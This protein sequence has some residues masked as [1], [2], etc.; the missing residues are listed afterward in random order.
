MNSVLNLKS[1]KKLEKLVA[2]ELKEA[3]PSNLSDLIDELFNEKETRV[4]GNT[5]GTDNKE[6]S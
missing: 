3:D 4:H 1:S 2:E 6:N 5:K